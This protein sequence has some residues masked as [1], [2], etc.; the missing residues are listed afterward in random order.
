[1]SRRKPPVWVILLCASLAATVVIKAVPAQD[2]IT[3]NW[4]ASAPVGMYVRTPME[5]ATFVS[6]CLRQEHTVFVFYDQL[7]SPTAPDRT[8]LLKAI[9]TRDPDG[10]LRVQGR[11]TYAIDSDLLGRVRPSQIQG[12]WRPFITWEM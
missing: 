10:S 3:F 1:M 12:W 4:T 9:A 11:G 5:R 7:C 6:F 2:K 8:A